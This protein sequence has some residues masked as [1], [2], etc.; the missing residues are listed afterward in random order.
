MLGLS[1][2][3]T[4]VITGKETAISRKLQ[5]RTERAQSSDSTVGGSQ[6]GSCLLVGQKDVKY[7]VG[8]SKMH[9][10]DWLL[11][12]D[13]LQHT[14]RYPRWADCSHRQEKEWPV[15][16]SSHTHLPP[17]ASLSRGS[18]VRMKTPMS[19]YRSVLATGPTHKQSDELL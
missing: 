5:D 3:W 10:H 18:D 6:E 14:H 16:F 13:H 1:Q 19:P 9:T 11:A 4:S 8:R 2:A 17:N 12:T 7:R 15:G